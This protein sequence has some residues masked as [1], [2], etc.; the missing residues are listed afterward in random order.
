MKK[1]VAAKTVTRAADS[2][3]ETEMALGTRAG[4]YGVLA[5]LSSLAF[6]VYPPRAFPF[7]GLVFM[8]WL[9]AGGL[10]LSIRNDLATPRSLR[11][12]PLIPALQFFCVIAIYVFWR[13][14][15]IF[16]PS[17]TDP[18]VAYAIRSPG[19]NFVVTIQLA[20]AAL[21]FGANAGLPHAE[22]ATHTWRAFRWTL[23][24]SAALF[25]THGLYQYFIGY[26]RDREALMA[27]LQEPGS[28]SPLMVQSL[29]HALGEKRIG[30][31]LGNGNVFAALLAVLAGMSLSLAGEKN[32][33][34]KPWNARG[35]VLAVLVY[36]LCF[37]T[38]LLTRSRGGLL[39]LAFTT[40]GGI[41]LLWTTRERNDSNVGGEIR[42]PKIGAGTAPPALKALLFLIPT[43]LV[44][45]MG[46]A[47]TDGFF[48]RFSNIST[49]RERLNYWGV[50]GKVWSLDWVFG[51][52][53]GSYE[54]LYARFKPPTARESRFP[55]SW[56]M[57]IG[58]ELGV[59]G[60]AL[61]V[62]FV[63][64]IGWFAVKAW[65]NR[66]ADATGAARE[67]LWLSLAVATLLFNGLFEYSM[68]SREFWALFGIITGGILSLS[69]PSIPRRGV[70][71]TPY[72]LLAFPF[73]ALIVYGTREQMGERWRW[74][75]Q[76][77]ADV[78][79]HVA[80]A[81]AY[82][83]AAAWRP[84]HEGYRAS[85]AMALL[86]SVA[87]GTE[88]TRESQATLNRTDALIHE[89]ETLNPLSPGMKRARAMFESRRGAEAAATRAWNEAVALYP[90]DAGYR[91]DRAQH[92]VNSKRIEAAR[93][94]LEFII[95]NKLPI[96]EIQKPQFE[97]LK[98]ETARQGDQA[99]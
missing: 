79:D 49:I 6:F 88:A 41:G 78:G 84:D 26:E 39:T 82:S 97:R 5:A 63:A 66:R 8:L 83:H 96:W 13:W 48:S 87:S 31:R 93:S 12:G 7:E 14:W 80:A 52:G 69:S 32:R 57:Q 50:A 20:V 90:Y 36:G 25:A 81:D 95:Q 40:A 61:F 27:S 21:F 91:L 4:A 28:H 68:Q 34:G 71:N 43:F 56:A 55:H 70:W 16:L 51:S 64:V 98:S 67:T 11:I 42:S 76:T 15:M 38:I 23:A 17:A 2:K 10:L 37:T 33:D 59:V 1:S 22:G 74:R 18:A 44:T 99:K 58:A 54:I 35:V 24:L 89:A 85:E 29:F 62:A 60:L 19:M 73:L 86:A 77:Y 9:V 75:A 72:V 53:P 45:L 3:P 47:G 92:A 30:G 94:D 65:R 46:A